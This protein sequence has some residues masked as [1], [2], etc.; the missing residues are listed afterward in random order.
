MAIAA[1]TKDKPQNSVTGSTIYPILLI[2]GICHMLNDTLQAVIPAM[3]PILERSMGLTFTQL[4]LI[5]FTLNMVSSVMQPAIGWYTDKRPMPYALPI[6]L[7]S[8]AVGIFGLAFA[9]SFATILLCVV[10]I[11]LGS[12]IFHPEGSRVA[13]MAAGPRRGL[14]Q[15]IYQVGG[16]TGQ[17]FAPLIAA[18]MLVPLGQPGVAWF[19]IVGMI[20]VG[21]LLYISRW[22]AG[23]LQTIRAQAKKAPAKAARSELHRKSALT[24]L[25]IIV[26][27]IFARSW[28]GNAISNFYAFYAI[29]QYGLTIK[30]SQTYIFLF[31]I[32]GAIGT[33]LGGPLADRFGKKTV[34]LISLLASFPLA[35][36]LP[37]AGPV[38]AYVLLGLIGV[39]LTSSFSVTVVYAQELFPGKIGTMSGLTVGFA[40]GMG[41]IG[42]VALGSFIDAFGLTPTMIGVAFLPILGILA[43][44]LPSDQTISKWNES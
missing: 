10:F 6:A 43:F 19:T 18:F 30:E 41:A 27:L 24:A 35:L 21:F 32:L 38:F 23:R 26:F 31:L 28:Y 14:A 34:I 13:N 16:N 37:F 36:L 22:Y 29:E 7:F 8:S 3:F 9:P 4:G 17:A 11:G 44:L 12:A 20:A 1:R 15:S 42:S 33:F 2:I 25:G 40:F 5:A 39:I